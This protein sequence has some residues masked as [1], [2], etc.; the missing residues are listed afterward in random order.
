MFS[1]LKINTVSCSYWLLHLYSKDVHFYTCQQSVCCLLRLIFDL[2][3]SLIKILFPLKLLRRRLTR[4][5][6]KI[7]YFKIIALTISEKRWELSS[8]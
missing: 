7:D 5:A 8:I 3:M 2:T 1:I 6:G 4:L